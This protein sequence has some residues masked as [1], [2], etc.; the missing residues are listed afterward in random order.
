MGIARHTPKVVQELWSDSMKKVTHRLTHTRT[1][2]AGAMTCTHRTIL[3]RT[4]GEEIAHVVLVEC[5]VLQ[6]LRCA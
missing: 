1:H 3:S 2:R 4:A 5:K 6:P